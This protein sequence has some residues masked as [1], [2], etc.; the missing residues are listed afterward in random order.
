MELTRRLN[1]TFLSWVLPISILIAAGA[2]SAFGTVTPPI[3]VDLEASSDSGPRDDDNLTNVVEPTIRITAAPGTQVVRVYRAGMFVGDAV[4]VS[5]VDYT[6]T[7]PG[8]TIVSGSNE[9]TARGA[10]A[11]G[12][13]ADSPNLIIT[14]DITSPN[15][16]SP[17]P[18]HIVALRSEQFQSVTVSFSEAINFET[19]GEGSLSIED[20]SIV[21]PSGPIPPNN[22][23]SAGVNTY[24]V[25]FAPQSTPGVYLFS[26]GPDISDV[27][28]NLL[29]QDLDGN[30]GEIPDDRMSFIVEAANV[31]LVIVADAVITA[32]DSTHDGKDLIVDGCVLT[33]DGNHTFD[34][35]RIAAGGIVTHTAN[36]SGFHLTIVGDLSVDYNARLSAN[37]RGYPR[38]QGPGAGTF[39]NGAGGSGG[40]F[41]GYGGYGGCNCSGRPAGGA[42]YGSVTLPM[43]LGSGGGDPGQSTG[44]SGGG[45]IRVDVGGR[46]QVDG[47]VSADGANGTGR[48][49]SGG[50]YTGGG[51]AGGSVLISAMSLSGSGTVS[52][53]GGNG[54]YHYWGNW[55]HGGGGSG[56]RIAVYSDLSGFTGQVLARG[57]SGMEYGAA[58]TTYLKTPELALGRLVL[59]NDGHVGAKTPTLEASEAYSRLDVSAAAN[60][61][62]PTGRVIS[63]N[64][65]NL[66]LE[67]DGWVTVDGSL[68]STRGGFDTLE[69]TTGAHFTLSSTASIVVPAAFV[70]SGGVLTLSQLGKLQCGLLDLQGG[71][72][73]INGN[74]RLTTQFIDVMTGGNL[75]L[76]TRLAVPAMAVRAGG[77]VTH[78]AGNTE[79]DL[80]V[81][82]DM[83][84]EAGGAVSAA[85]RG[86][87]PG[88]GPGA[89]QAVYGAGGGGGGYAGAGGIG[90]TNGA[91][92]SPGGEPYCPSTV[93]I[94]LGSGGGNPGYEV[95]GDGG[96]AIRLSVGGTLQLDG[97]VDVSGSDG[98]ARYV[99]GG[100][101]T[102]GGG[103]G[104]HV[105]ISATTLVG[106]GAISA[107]GGDGRY[108]YWGNWQYGGGG[109]G[110]R[111]AIRG[112]R[113]AFRGQFSASGGAGFVRGE[114]GSVMYQVAEPLQLN[115]RTI[116]H[117]SD[118]CELELWEFTAIAGQQVRLEEVRLDGQ[119]IVFDLHGPSGWVG[120]EG[121]NSTSELLTLPDSGT[122]AL[123]ARAVRDLYNSV[124]SFVLRETFV[125][126]L[127]RGVPYVGQ[128]VG[129]GQ[130][131]LFRIQTILDSPLRVRLDDS[132]SNN[133]SELY[134]R[135]GLPP[136][137]GQYDRRSAHLACSDQEVFVPRAT[138]DTWYV[139][140]YAASVITPGS[141]T[142][143][144]DAAP[145]LLSSVT[146]RRH[147]N[148]APANL[149]IRGGGLTPA[150]QVELVSSSGERHKADRVD[151]LSDE[152]VI[153]RFASRRVPPGIYT[154]VASLADGASEQLPQ[155]FEMTSGSGSKLE[156][157]LIVPSTLGYHG[158]ATLWV[159]YA[160]TG[161][162]SMPAPL[163]IVSASQNN[164]EGAIL[165][166][167]G[168]LPARGFW[169]SGL[170]DGF[171]TKVQLLASG[172]TPGLLQPGER[173]R[174][175]IQYAGWLKPWDFAYPPISFSLGILDGND[176][177][178]ADWDAVKD[179]TR[180]DGVDPAAW[181]AVFA[182]FTSGAGRTWGDFAS[183]IAENSAYL[184][185]RGVTLTD[186]QQLL[187]FELAQADGLH[188]VRT[189]AASTDAALSAPG[190]DLVFARSFP[191]SI[192]A[193]YESGPF[194]RGWSHNW[195]F[196]LVL[197]NDGT[198]DVFEPGHS[199]RRFQPDIRGGYFPME[200]DHATLTDLGA[201][202]F[203]ITETTGQI[204][205]FRQGRPS[206][207]E[208][209]NGNRILLLYANDRLVRLEHSSGG[210]LDLTYDDSGLVATVSDSIGRM[211]AYSYD[212][213]HQHLEMARSFDGRAVTYS[214]SLGAGIAREHALVAESIEAGPSR[215]FE[216]DDRGRLVTSYRDGRAEVL[217]FAFGT[218]GTFEVKDGLDHRFMVDLDQRGHPLKVEDP[219]GLSSRFAYDNQS[220]LVRATAPDGTWDGFSFDDA[221]NLLMHENTARDIT[222]FG[223]EH[224]FNQ[225]TVLTNAMA[226]TTRYEHD[227]VGDLTAIAYADGSRETWS[228]RDGL[229]I[230]WTNRR[231]Q[232]L[233]VEYTSAGDLSAVVN[234]D[235]SRT[236]YSYDG[237]RRLVETSDAI[238]SMTYDYDEG[239]RIVR[240]NYSGGKFL[241]YE[242]DLLGRRHAMSNEL[243]YRLEYAYDAIGRLETVTDESGTEV[244]HYQYDQ[245]GRLDLKRLG[246]G[247][248]T[249]YKYDPDSRLMQLSNYDGND[250]L[251]SAFRYTY[252]DRS[253]VVSMRTT[254]GV[255][256]YAYDDH[257]RLAS[258]TAPD[259]RHVDYQYDA[260]GNRIAA[261]DGGISTDYITNEIDQYTRVGSKTF[262]YDAD[263][264]LTRIADGATI[265]SLAY[266][267]QNRLISVVNAGGSWEFAYDA[268][269]NRRLITDASGTI[270]LVVD[271]IGFGDVVAEYA[272]A[273]G[274]IRNRFD[275]GFGLL[276]RSDVAAGSS[277]YS[278]DG[279]GNTSEVTGS[280]GE[281]RSSFA[282]F[283]FGESRSESGVQGERFLYAGEFGVSTDPDGLI[284]MRHRQ[285]LPELGRFI[286]PDPIGLAG[287]QVNLYSYVGNNPVGQVD[288]WGLDSFNLL[289]AYL[290]LTSSEGDALV[291]AVG[292]RA[293]RVM[294]WI[295][296]RI[297][298]LIAR[299]NPLAIHDAASIGGKIAF[300]AGGLNYAPLK[301]VAGT[302][303]GR[304]G[305]LI[306]DVWKL[307]YQWLN[308]ILGPIIY[309]EAFRW[310]TGDWGINPRYTGQS[311]AV[312]PVGAS[313]PNEKTGPSGVGSRRFV[314]PGSLLPYKIEFENDSRAT[315]PAQI[316]TIDDQLDPN[317]RWETFDLTGITFGDVRISVPPRTQ[318]F[319]TTVQVRFG[320]VDF[321]VQIEAGIR[322]ATG[323]VYARFYSL[324]PGTGLPPAVGVGFL[325]PEDGSGRGQGSVLYVVRARDSIQNRS[326][327]VRN[328]AR[329]TFDY[330]ETIATN[331]VDPHDAS[332]GTDPNKEAWVTLRSVLRDTG[333]DDRL[334]TR[335]R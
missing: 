71:S 31:D 37:G 130:A 146:P 26:I 39:G 238:G 290:G 79:F 60:Y 122:Y 63:L 209:P 114:D 323:T 174:Q 76:N 168:T 201:D 77:L 58:G 268:L 116:A 302:P 204:M 334:R 186:I 156:T 225:L 80:D 113:S 107:D 239:D 88:S 98:S 308:P 320:N 222:V 87:G 166:L 258:W 9:I 110:G 15:A 17:T 92:R 189:V 18:N 164:R 161:D 1:R 84:I 64:V 330:Q 131:Q 57:G 147:G 313:D 148:G 40:G 262:E 247:V 249:V 86:H 228:F 293:G 288:P 203:S 94:A 190:F 165:K 150:T 163:L 188:V 120:F 121:L 154:V 297:L 70:S 211:T 75:E 112:D 179:T 6:Y 332:K 34:S 217:N 236:T 216:Y 235:G 43:D 312:T 213:S 47:V 275:H 221:G 129:S 261:I 207:V 244:V 328:V 256:D 254:E 141:Y 299:L 259:G 281:V 231:G 134:I 233:S 175:A 279:N 44:A 195:D 25:T 289:G 2:A 137:R 149:Y 255:W 271:P 127:D 283:P 223:Y 49:V 219:L 185:S 241:E 296:S 242:Y 136:T 193:R 176:Q 162:V 5:E 277:F 153:A 99:S 69:V 139:L 253:R 326:V 82:D 267:E 67:S 227:N 171:A 93:P 124:F 187:K 78:A 117:F 118:S 310:Y 160:N 104:G 245:V 177:T 266:D 85:G 243:G 292:R 301:F 278:F 11:N 21:G 155:A 132:S 250:V 97:V 327:L 173:V 12:E 119:G 202:V 89:G 184:S 90:G 181:E 199:R 133:C 305:L 318:H 329:I 294:G 212:E 54:Y 300:A 56:G 74:A 53:N 270:E 303:T 103:S 143:L 52:A 30:T 306:V 151:V 325:P 196:R 200:G 48:Y 218:T 100:R 324:D 180:P 19:G 206:S 230:S 4:L 317:L 22:I 232:T 108:H 172:A 214:Y 304:I 16:N 260:V 55:Q 8:G 144:L 50:R 298:S 42:P 321:V 29:D 145:I 226:Q 125:T 314:E 10:D 286:S 208:D 95:G 111:I 220:N 101:Y 272:R 197:G 13:S 126:G 248:Y 229:P 157:N 263:G 167:S 240:I 335:R 96:G 3:A 170:P 246:N 140:L 291:R 105:L 269:G 276:R 115:L 192:L 73:A 128:F 83:T 159:E 24:R 178:P 35:L 198:V 41:A 66:R 91:A 135:R 45:V 65:D 280:L 72:V 152:E 158:V 315:A 194:G 183:M 265:S 46:L 285:F 274:Q 287:R 23:E 273:S 322:L 309:D 182:N 264:N 123:Q 138:A 62:I 51:G 7:F 234:V 311:A 191:N 215:F 102:G 106:A 142:L 169:T 14:L 319:E 205:T 32:N 61:V 27:A 224:R 331:Q 109:S 282:Y 316:V 251:L 252:D 307:A 81:E 210:S 20:V 38:G 295:G 33:I 36:V 333:G 237:R 257:G 284:D 59:D 68:L 28:G